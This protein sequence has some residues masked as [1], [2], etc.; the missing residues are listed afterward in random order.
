MPHEPGHP[1]SGCIP[2]EWA[3]DEVPEQSRR[4]RIQEIQLELVRPARNSLPQAGPRDQSPSKLSI[5][6]YPRAFTISFLRM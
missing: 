3:G 2:G 6:I 5:V 4:R 1:H